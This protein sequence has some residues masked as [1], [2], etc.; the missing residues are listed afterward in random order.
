MIQ[1]KN[2]R[3]K[4]VQSKTLLRTLRCLVAA[5]CFAASLISQNLDEA[6]TAS[7]SPMMSARA[8]L[9]LEGVADNSM[10][11]LSIQD[12]ALVFLRGKGS[13]IQIP[14]TAIQ[15]V[16]LS[17]EDKQVGGTPMAIGRAAAPFEGGRVIGVF[18]HK[19][20]DFV[21]VEYLD[22]N[23]GFHGTVYELNKG[24]GRVLADELGAKGVH[25]GGSQIDTAKQ[26]METTN[27][28]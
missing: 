18:T 1:S 26:E 7:S 12:N 21:T 13:V 19:K 25:V 2:M 20:Y 9:G 6:K 10:G 17:Q 11:T 22:A 27:A 23:G 5:S 8:V 14:L 24:Q 15:G 28:K 3:Y 16:F 4:I